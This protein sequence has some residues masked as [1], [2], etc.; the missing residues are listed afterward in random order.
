MPQFVCSNCISSN[1]ECTH[2]GTMT[3]DEY[4]PISMQS[5]VEEILTSSPRYCVPDSKEVVQQMIIDLATYSRN[6]ENRISTLVKKL[7]A[8]NSQ[9]LV[10]A[11]T[12]TDENAESGYYSDD[13]NS[14]RWLSG[15]MSNIS[16]QREDDGRKKKKRFFGNSSTMALLK[17]IWRLPDQSSPEGFRSDKESE[18]ESE[19]EYPSDVETIA[20]TPECSKVY[21]V[22][23]Q[24]KLHTEPLLDFIFPTHD[25]ILSLSRTYFDYVQ[26]TVPFLHRPTFERG[27]SE[28]LYLTNR[29]FGA[30]VLSVCA[31][32][33]RGSSDPRVY[34]EDPKKNAKAGYEWYTQIEPM[35]GWNCLEPISLFELQTNINYMFFVPLWLP[36]WSTLAHTI[37]AAQELETEKELW[38]RAFWLLVAFDIYL[39]DYLGRPGLMVPEDYDLDLP[40]ECDD[41]YWPSEQSD[42]GKAFKQ[43]EG[44]PSL[45]SHWIGRLK[46]FTIFKYSQRTIYAAR[47]PQFIMGSDE[48]WRQKVIAQID[49]SLN[50]WVEKIPSHPNAITPK[51]RWDSHSILTDDPEQ[52]DQ[53]SKD[54][55][56]IFATQA[57][58]LYSMYYFFQI[59][60]HRPFIT[61]TSG[62]STTS[63]ADESSSANAS[64]HMA[65][66]V[67]AA[68]SCIHLLDVYSQKYKT[69]PIPHIYVRLFSSAVI[70][71]LNISSGRLTGLSRNSTTDRESVYKCIEILRR[72]EGKWQVNRRCRCSGVS[73]GAGPSQSSFAVSQN[74]NATSNPVAIGGSSTQHSASVI[75]TSSCSNAEDSFPTPSSFSSS[76]TYT[77]SGVGPSMDTHRSDDT[78]TVANDDQHL[79]SFHLFDGTSAESSWNFNNSGYPQEETTSDI[80][81]F[82]SSFPE[83][84]L[85]SCGQNEL[86]GQP[87]QPYLSDS[88]QS[89]NRFAIFQVPQQ[90]FEAELFRE[91]EMMGESTVF[92]F[93]REQNESGESSNN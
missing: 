26:I 82:D 70:L 36:N 33:A 67:N 24:I 80:P 25:L 79:D 65:I 34:S 68:R 52:E 43:P 37:R 54:R 45:L 85:S 14:I 53:L 72:F 78:I 31:C 42:P 3:K 44:K 12:L 32:G 30:L 5:L 87:L 55:K 6:L 59:Q 47:R 15:F 28:R 60:L 21:P 89:Q 84:T 46:L 50:S 69:P 93:G 29:E 61:K 23:S 38:K 13:N 88:G 76:I 7:S 63:A 39:G 1:V 20:T 10:D 77:D 2:R 86:N 8:M 27:L 64:V 81:N 92:D 40:I 49:S 17:S 91:L 71:V 58:A 90:N 9:V 75:P 56:R 11:P 48:D 66:C 57:A 18:S 83:F 41:E 22:P 16:I 51:V 62:V 19:S 73:P 4:S 74:P 35:R